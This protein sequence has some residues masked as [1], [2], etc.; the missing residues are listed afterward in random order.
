MTGETPGFLD[1]LRLDGRV[2]VITGGGSGLGRASAHMLA[3]LGAFVAV[4][5]RDEGAAQTVAD[6]IVSA[7][8]QADAETMNVSYEDQID[9][10][11]DAIAATRGR[12]D[13]L[14]NSAGIGGYPGALEMD[15]DVWRKIIQV[16]LEGSFLCARAAARHMI[17]RKDGAIVNIASIFGLVGSVAVIALF[18]VLVWRGVRIALSAMERGALYA[19]CLAFGISTWLGVQTFINLGVNMGVLPTK[20]LTLPMISFGRSSLV[21]IL[22]AIGMLMRID[23]ENRIKASTKRRRAR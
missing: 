18:G 3:E 22:V 4:T 2:A 6:E 7:G 11:F 21:V 20:G 17:P 14:V 13:I 1:K 23:H 9:A 19:A 15:S 12:L 5:D 10:T 8:G 16:N